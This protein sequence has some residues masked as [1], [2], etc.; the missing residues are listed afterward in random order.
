[1][2]RRA[3]AEKESDRAKQRIYEFDDVKESLKPEE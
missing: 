3:R 2:R 1:M